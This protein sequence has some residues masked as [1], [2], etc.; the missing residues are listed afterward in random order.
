MLQTVF[1][2]AREKPSLSLSKKKSN[3]ADRITKAHQHKYG[4]LHSVIPLSPTTTTRTH[5]SPAATSHNLNVLYPL[6]GGENK[7]KESPPPLQGSRC[8]FVCLFV[9][10]FA[11][12][13]NNI[14][15]HNPDQISPPTHTPSE[16]SKGGTGERGFK[17]RQLGICLLLFCCICFFWAVQRKTQRNKKKGVKNNTTPTTHTY[18]CAGE[19]NHEVRPKQ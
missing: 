19:G 7:K 12:C 17:T 4:S 6:A 2:A 9:C 13:S 18:C 11:C 1:Q 16:Y 10:L 3:A 15:N 14:C 5:E 8:L